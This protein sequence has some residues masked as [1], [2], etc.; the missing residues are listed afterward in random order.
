MVAPADVRTA[1]G[2]VLAADGFRNADRLTRF[3]RLTV[4]KALAGEA[5]ELKEYRIGVDV[6]DRGADFDPRVDPI[7]RVEARRLRTKLSE[8][9]EGPGSDDPVRIL[10]PKGGYAPVFEQVGAAEARVTH[11]VSRRW[12]WLSVVAVGIAATVIT[13]GSKASSDAVTMVVVPGAQPTDM[14]FAD[15]LAEAVSAELSRSPAVRVVG[16]PVL[17]EYRQRQGGSLTATMAQIA[18][19]LRADAVLFVSVRRSGQRLRITVHLMNPE[20]GKKRWAGDYERGVE[21]GFA[22]QKEL[23]RAISDEVLNGLARR[24]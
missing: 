1:L 13:F 6:Y 24:P 10:L 16:W 22:V 2:R 12:I 21:E 4:E 18:K 17:V 8:Y 20:Q 19:D 11:G 5:A 3:L 23:A 7:V 9:Y 15:G 14:E